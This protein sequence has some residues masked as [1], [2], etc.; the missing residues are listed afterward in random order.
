MSSSE[1]GAPATTSIYSHF[2]FTSNFTTVL[3][4][5]V[6]YDDGKYGCRGQSYDDD[7][8]AIGD[9]HFLQKKI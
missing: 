1:E 2:H 7:E 6:S 4:L 9:M 8:R 5:K 3:T